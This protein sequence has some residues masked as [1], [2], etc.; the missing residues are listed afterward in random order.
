MIKQFKIYQAHCGKNSRNTTAVSHSKQCLSVQQYNGMYRL[1]QK[2][3][4]YSRTQRVELKISS[5][6][7][8]SSTWKTLKCCVLQWTVLGPLL[9]SVYI[10]D[11]PCSFDNSS[12]VIMCTD[13]TNILTASN[14]Y[15]VFNTNFR[16]I[17]YSAVR[18]FQIDQI[19][20]GLFGRASSSWNKLKCELA[21]TR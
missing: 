2:S 13:D 4:L 7:N 5:T 8:Y 18:L 15:E 1:I 9:F 12:N 11:V 3:C 14:W 19:V 16:G 17:I 6:C 20:C 21:A 10:T